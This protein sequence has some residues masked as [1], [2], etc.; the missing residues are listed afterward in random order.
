VPVYTEFHITKASAWPR[1]KYRVSV[2]LNGAASA[3]VEFDVQ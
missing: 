2:T 1:G 3:P